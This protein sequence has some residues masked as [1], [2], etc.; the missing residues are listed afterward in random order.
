MR[1]IGPQEGQWQNRAH[2]FAT[3]A[4]TMRQVLV[5]Y[6]RRRRAGKRGGSDARKVD[7]D[8]QLRSTPDHIEEVLAL[9]EILERLARID[10]RQ[11]RLV[12]LRFFG[13][14]NV[15]ETA[16]VMGV[17]PKTIKREWRS[18]KAWLHRELASEKTG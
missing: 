11:S 7:F 1:L 18:A 15:E 14:L 6:S 10:P 2:F 4:R 5:D 16:E 13:G 12:E 8:D 9:D 17:S 3:A